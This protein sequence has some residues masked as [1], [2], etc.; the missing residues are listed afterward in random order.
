MLLTLLFLSVGSIYA[1]P[2]SIKLRLVDSHTNAPVDFAS[3]YVSKDGTVKGAKHSMTDENGHATIVKVAPGK[4]I[5]KAELLGY[6]LKEMP[7]EVK[8]GVLDLGEIKMDPDV[9][10]LEQVVVSAVGNQIIVKKDTI[11]YNA[12][13]IK[14]T[15]NDMLED[16]IKKLPGFEIDSDGNIT[17]NGEVVKKVMIDGKEF[18]LDDPQLASKNIPAKIINKVKVVE[19]KSEQA[20]FTGIDDGEEETVL[21]LSFKPGMMKGWFGNASAGGGMDLVKGIDDQYDPR[22]QAAA[23][24]GR[25]TEENQISFILNGNNTNNRGFQDMAGEMMG[26]MRGGGRMGGGGNSG[27]TTSWMGGINGN[28]YLADKTIEL[29]GN[30]LYS[31]SDRVL[32]QNTDKTTMISDTEKLNTKNKSKDITFSQ[33]HRAGGRFDWDI[34]EKASILFTPNFNYGMGRYQESTEYASVNSVKGKVNDGYSTNSGENDNWTASGRLLYRQKIGKTK[35]RTLSVNINY[36]FSENNLE[37]RNYSETGNY[38]DDRKVKTSIVDQRI[39]QMS[40]AQTLGARLSYTEPL[41]RNFFIEASYRYNYRKNN[42]TKSTYN[43]NES[44]LYNVLDTL[45]SSEYHNTFINQTAQLSLVKQEEK[46]TLQVGFNAQPARTISIENLLREGRDSTLDYSVVN[47]SPSA[48]FDYRFSDSEFLRVN[49]RGSTNQPSLTQLQPVP[50]NTNPLYIRLGNPSLQ[51]E[52]T[53]RI[54]ARYRNTNRD[55]FSTINLTFNASYVKDD[56]IN[57]SWYNSNGVQFTAPINSKE[58]TFSTSARVMYNTPIAKSNFSVMANAYT[59]LTRGLNYTG[60]G[61]VATLEEIIDDLVAGKTT[62]INVG[63]RLNFTYRTDSFEARLGGRAGYKNAW[64]TIQEQEKPATWT[65]FVDGEVSYTAPWGTEIKTD[66]RYTFYI[67]FEDGYNIPRMVWNAEISQ[68]L[69]KKKATLRFKVYDIL[70]QAMNVYRNTAD[71]YVED[72]EQNTLG[73]Y[74]MLSFTYRFGNFGGNRM[75]PGG[76]GGHGR[77]PMGPPRR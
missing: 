37:S 10:T 5:F 29:H 44:G 4:Y 47:Y 23:M 77:G 75:G 24:A 43:K 27:I 22:F 30:Y 2:G 25:F 9:N 14:T 62:T 42:S 64:Y 21:D 65:N 67:G 50:D 56:I 35:G 59:T 19:K 7:V 40:D 76:P 46:Y 66:A 34:T 13:L 58:P 39:F 36:N 33:G 26:G 32:E 18:F 63:A 38:E 49:Y 53:H 57:A 55:K 45:Y 73:Q 1:Q 54:N 52:F 70:N 15:D 51:P 60:N 12:A 17:A 69:F 71:N 6:K 16:L 3:V 20:E 68:L 41:G 48:R 61:D 74:F 8:K 31:G 11:E 28:G 72:V